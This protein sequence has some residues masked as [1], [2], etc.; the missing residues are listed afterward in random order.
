MR[1]QDQVRDDSRMSDAATLLESVAAGALSAEDAI[2]KWPFPDKECIGLVGLALHHLHHFMADDDI[3][4]RDA[5][6]GERQ[7]RELLEYAARLR[8]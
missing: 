6:Y 3:R 1:R 5:S 8:P 2:L 4:E 7:R